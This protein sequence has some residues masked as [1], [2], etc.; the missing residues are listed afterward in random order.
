MSAESMGRGMV[1]DEA[2]KLGISRARLYEYLRRYRTNPTIESLL[3]KTTGPKPGTTTLSDDVETIIKQAIEEFFLSDQKPKIRDLLAEVARR[4]RMARIADIPSYKAVKSRVERV[5]LGERLRTREG[6]DAATR[7]LRHNNGHHK[8]DYALEEVQFDHTKVDTF[9]VDKTFR[10]TIQ[11]PY[12]TLGIDVA[13]SA[14]VGYY[15]SL[16]APSTLS[17]AMTIS[18]SVLPKD[19]QHPLSCG[20]GWDYSTPPTTA[21]EALG[22]NGCCSS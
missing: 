8:A 17:I 16:E 12:L 9:V 5:D 10:E 22:W 15:L 6:S 3:P 7:R 1:E 11:R 13:S 2:R 20:C 21:E 19:G 4:C 14:I 18:Q